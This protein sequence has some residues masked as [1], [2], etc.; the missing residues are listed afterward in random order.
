MKVLLAVC[1]FMYAAPVAAQ[2][3]VPLIKRRAPSAPTIADTI[4]AAI[5]VQQGVLAES[6]A[7]ADS[8]VRD[9]VTKRL[10][11]L[12]RLASRWRISSCSDSTKKFEVCGFTSDPVL[13]RAAGE[14]FWGHE[15]GDGLVLG[16]MLNI[17]GLGDPGAQST[18]VELAADLWNM[19][20]ISLAGVVQPKEDDDEPDAPDPAADATGEEQSKA[21][22]FLNGGG[23]AVVTLLRPF[24]VSNLIGWRS[25]LLG[26]AQASFSLPAGGQSV[27]DSMKFA[28][29]GVDVQSQMKGARS[30]IGGIAVLHIGQ[31]IGSN[32]FY[33][34]LGEDG[35]F[36]VANAA[37]GLVIDQSVSITWTRFLL[38]PSSL[39]NPD[40]LISVKFTR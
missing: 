1:G 23:P 25:L 33:D 35:T 4:A 28:D 22:H 29:F 27:R 24:A 21:Q 14:T 13:A 32:R 8:L 2:G 11:G 37:I 6:G 15:E 20:R 30:R 31:I 40:G 36:T 17:Q 19:T 18:Y 26:R 39:K 3:S 34:N 5:A 38:G 9:T 12:Q 7:P 16:K 10:T